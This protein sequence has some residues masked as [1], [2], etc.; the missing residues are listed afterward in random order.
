MQEG[1]KAFAKST[2]RKFV[3][4]NLAGWGSF[5]GEEVAGTPGALIGA[6]VPATVGATVKGAVKSTARGIGRQKQIEMRNNLLADKKE[7]AKSTLGSTAAVPRAS[8]IERS[9]E[10]APG[11]HGPFLRNAE[12]NRISLQ[13]RFENLLGNKGYAEETAGGYVAGALK[14][15][16]DRFRRTSRKLYDD[17]EKLIGNRNT[18]V[19]IRGTRDTLRKFAVEEGDDF[20]N[21][22]NAVKAQ[23]DVASRILAE[24][25]GPNMSLVGMRWVDANHLRQVIGQQISLAKSIGDPTQGILKQIY[26]AVSKDVEAGAIKAGGK[27]AEAAF[28]RAGAHWRKNRRVVD[29]LLDPMFKRN[30]QPELL[31][32]EVV[33][34]SLNRPTKL[35]LIMKGLNGEQKEYFAKTFVSKLGNIDD[36]TGKIVD[37]LWSPG[38]LLRNWSKI[39]QKQKD[40]LFAGSAELKKLQASIERYMKVIK[41]QQRS[42]GILANPSGTAG[43][44][45][46]A[47]TLQSALSSVGKIATFGLGGTIAFG[48]AFAGLATIGTAMGGANIGARLMTDP[49]F[50]NWLTKASAAP[51]KELPRHIARLNNLANDD[52]EFVQALDAFNTAAALEITSQRDQQEQQ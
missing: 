12:K 36:A 2:T 27:A 9:F 11:S 7:G 43:T 17:A 41:R 32:R 39:P 40:A 21:V 10:S 35:R 26:K 19:S 24:M 44:G 34:A 48:S 23:D 18:I 16:L 14:R 51:F 15:R 33:G 46:A 30:I 20:A 8:T 38:R 31:F 47:A 42:A 52:P 28:K 22:F 3:G 49:R 45:L 50:L 1:A 37:E 13:Q 29:R 6:F 5:V 4:S 25:T